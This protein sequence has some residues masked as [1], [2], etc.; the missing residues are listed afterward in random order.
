MDNS[1][2]PS[3]CPTLSNSWQTAGTDRAWTGFRLKFDILITVWLIWVE[4][5]SQEVYKS[6]FLCYLENLNFWPNFTSVKY[7]VQVKTS[8]QD[9]HLRVSNSSRPVL[10]PCE[11]GVLLT[12]SLFRYILLF[13]VNKM[14]LG[15]IVVGKF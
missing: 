2:G 14:Q 1:I 7:I 15:N 13:N 5:D 12:K 8:L 3:S 6:G 10:F 4:F 11:N 9:L